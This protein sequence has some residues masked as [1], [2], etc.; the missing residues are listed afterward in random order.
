MGTQ[1]RQ[2][3]AIFLTVT[4]S[5]SAVLYFWSFQGA[6]LSIVAPV[7][8]WAPGVGALIAQRVVYGTLAGLGWRRGRWQYLWIAVMLPVAYLTA[9]YVPV[10]LTGLGKLDQT[11]LWPVLV[12]APVGILGNV[13]LALG[14]ELGWRGLL[15]PTLVRGWGVTGGSI[16]SGLIW[17]LWHVP[18][19]VSG[20][21]SG[22][23]PAWYSV[24]CFTVSAT[25]VAVLL[26]WLRLRSGSLWPST[27][28]HA[29]HNALI[30]GVLDHSTIDTGWTTWLTTEFGVGLSIAATIIAAYCW[31]RRDRLTA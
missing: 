8:M 21:Y 12:L 27:L 30:Q 18:L 5:L 16:A 22:G 11:A 13:P 26:A 2:S 24:L 15:A 29:T 9:I 19:I 7:L 14:E 20:D 10:W 23:A 3:L 1:D 25:G 6:P 31:Q 17:S 4:F 28:F